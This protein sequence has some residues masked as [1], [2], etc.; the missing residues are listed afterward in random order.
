MIMIQSEQIDIDKIIIGDRA[1]KDFGDIDALAKSISELGLLQPILVARWGDDTLLVDGNRRILA[2]QKL[3]NKTIPAVIFNSNRFFDID[4]TLQAEYDANMVRKDFAPSEAVALADHI[5]SWIETKKRLDEEAKTE[6]KDERGKLPRKEYDETELLKC[7]QEN[8]NK[9]VTLTSKSKNDKDYKRTR[10]KVADAVGMSYKTLEKAKAVVKS[11]AENPENA[12]LVK[13]MDETG[14]VDTAYKELQ[15]RKQGNGN[16]SPEKNIGLG[17]LPKGNVVSL[18]VKMPDGRQK[19]MGSISNDWFQ[20]KNVLNWI[21]ES[22]G[23]G[24][25]EKDI[26]IHREGNIVKVFDSTNV[27]ALKGAIRYLMDRYSF[28]GNLIDVLAEDKKS[29]S[30]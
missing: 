10:D 14:K 5:K 3:G 22:V 21:I 7:T 1:R 29:D 23:L 6:L 24:T 9:N 20:N 16:L 13:K 25:E 4:Q 17:N 19:K 18:I 30:I 11:A 26:V 8:Y 2:F 12:D 15:D 27:E 28:T